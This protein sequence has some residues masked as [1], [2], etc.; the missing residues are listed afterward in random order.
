[1]I[2][3]FIAV[4]C[5]ITFPISLILVIALPIAQY[6]YDFKDIEKKFD[7]LNGYTKDY[8]KYYLNV[9]IVFVFSLVYLLVY[10]YS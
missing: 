7:R 8:L 9:I 5:W 10:Y 2:L 1:M 3:Q 4:L 6:R